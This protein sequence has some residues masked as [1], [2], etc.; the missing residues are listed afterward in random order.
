MGGVVWYF[1]IGVAV[2]VIVTYLVTGLVA[3]AQ[4]ITVQID[5]RDEQW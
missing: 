5:R 3:L 1:G 4:V 2:G